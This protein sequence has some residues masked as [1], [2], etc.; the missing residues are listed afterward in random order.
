VCL[1]NGKREILKEKKEKRQKRKEEGKESKNSKEGKRRVAIADIFPEVAPAQELDG[2]DELQKRY[3]SAFPIATIAEAPTD[4]REETGGIC[5][6]VFSGEISSEIGK[7]EEEDTPIKRHRIRPM[8]EQLLGKP[9]PRAVY[10]DEEG[11]YC[12]PLRVIFSSNCY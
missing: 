4:D 7:R 12:W 11:M 6:S 3:C 1:E 2:K 5:G 9:R 8:S 10:E